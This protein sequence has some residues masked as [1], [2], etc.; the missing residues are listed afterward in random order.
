MEGRWH[1]ARDVRDLPSFGAFSCR[2]VHCINLWQLCHKKKGYLV[3]FFLFMLRIWDSN[4]VNATVRWTVA[5]RAGPR[6]LLTLCPVGTMAPN[7]IIHP[8]GVLLFM[9]WILL[10]LC[11]P[12]AVSCQYL[13]RNRN[14]FRE[15]FCFRIKKEKYSKIIHNLERRRNAADPRWELWVCIMGLIRRQ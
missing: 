8:I 15:F 5:G 3:V 7:P 14:R 4:H 6:P 13:S 12:D 2:A 10:A 11:P 9:G 1:P